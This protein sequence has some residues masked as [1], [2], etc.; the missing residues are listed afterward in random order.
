M[1]IL[2]FTTTY[3]NLYKPIIENLIQQGHKTTVI[4]DPI[5]P[6]DPKLTCLDLTKNKIDEWENNV[7]IFWNNQ[8]KYLNNE[9][10]V[11]LSLNGTSITTQIVNNIKQ[12]N[13]GI[14]TVL[15]A[16]DGFKYLNFKPIENAFENRYSFDLD[17]CLEN[18]NWHLLPFYHLCKYQR[19]KEHK[20]D[21]FCIGTNH[22]NRLE[23]IRKIVTN[24]DSNKHRLLIKILPLK[25][26]LIAYLKMIVLSPINKRCRMTL[27]F[28]LGLIERRFKLNKMISVEE[29]N[30]LLDQSKCI[31]DDVREG[32]AGL[33]PRFIWALA[34]NKKILTSNTEAYDYA[35]VNHENTCVISK[36]NPQVPKHFFNSR[37]E[38]KRSELLDTLYIDNWCRILLGESYLPDYSISSNHNEIS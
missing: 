32:Q 22:D 25:Y 16:W 37:T 9:Y 18:N 3:L 7:N 29:Y 8:K 11:F 26:S 33:S 2:V 19:S 23:F 17:D 30:Q 10:D 15:Y 20:Y 36:H 34:A 24:I 6:N 4:I 35:F 31:I 14:K 1:N 27:L 28:K 38:T 5:F 21:L 12:L 13:K